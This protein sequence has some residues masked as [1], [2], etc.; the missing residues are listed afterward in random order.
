[1]IHFPAALACETYGNRTIDQDG[2]ETTAYDWQ[3]PLVAPKNTSG[4]FLPSCGQLKYL[5][6]HSTTLSACMEA[7]ENSTPAECDYKDKIKWFSTSYFYWSSTENSSYPYYARD[8]RF[9]YGNAS[10]SYKEYPRGVRA[11]LAF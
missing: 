7:V 2:Q 8:V 5:Y 9:D 11:V 1:M 4:W 6:Q 3:K 10:S